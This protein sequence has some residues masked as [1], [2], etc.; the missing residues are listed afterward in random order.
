MNVGMH[1]FVLGKK[2]VQVC[3]KADKEGAICR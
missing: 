3:L 1:T 2:T